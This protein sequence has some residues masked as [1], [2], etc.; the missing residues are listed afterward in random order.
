[1]FLGGGF[2]KVVAKARIH[3]PFAIASAVFKIVID[4]LE[5]SGEQDCE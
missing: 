2:D 3:Q 4:Y 1:M 5:A